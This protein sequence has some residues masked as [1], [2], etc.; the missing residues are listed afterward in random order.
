ME[1]IMDIGLLIDGGERDASGAASFERMDPFT[2]RLA[3]RAAAA[4]VADANAAVD[5]AAAAF[6][7]WSRTGPGERRALLSK[8]AD[9]MASKVGEF[10]S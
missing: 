7:A 8:A 4:S 9:V 3:T 10:T 2:G 1:T 6:P 5:A